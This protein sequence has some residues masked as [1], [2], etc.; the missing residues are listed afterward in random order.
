MM[1]SSPQRHMGMGELEEPWECKAC[2]AELG[3][4][5]P[6]SRRTIPDLSTVC[7]EERIYPKQILRSPR[8]YLVVWAEV[9]LGTLCFCLLL[10]EWTSL[11]YATLGCA[12]LACASSTSKC[13]SLVMFG[14]IG[15]QQEG[16]CASE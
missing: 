2:L 5:F 12:T 15:S 6:V 1:E 14:S 11:R 3:K 10:V 9:G 7:L 13:W 8:V 16:Q 4:M